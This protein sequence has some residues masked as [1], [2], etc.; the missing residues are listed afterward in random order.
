MA[1]KFADWLTGLFVTDEQIATENEVE[2][3][4]RRILERQ[5]KEGKVDSKEYRETFFD[6]DEAGDT[7][8]DFKAENSSLAATV[9]WWVWVLGIAAILFFAFGAGKKF[10]RATP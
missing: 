5:F 6:I 9:P 2:E 3:G 7:L 10:T 4:Q 1:N 8:E